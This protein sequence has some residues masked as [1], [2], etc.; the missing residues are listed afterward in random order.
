MEK[1]HM[2]AGQGVTWGGFLAF[3]GLSDVHPALSI[4][5]FAL[6]VAGTVYSIGVARQSIRQ[7]K[8]EAAR[9]ALKLCAECRAQLVK[10]NVCPLL[11][12]ERP[13]D[14]PFNEKRL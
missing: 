12:S 10:P 13:V 7:H 2:A 5:L 1:V 9:E 11:P 4:M 6:S 14:C 8:I 3:L